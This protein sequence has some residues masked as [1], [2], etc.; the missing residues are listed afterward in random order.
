MYIRDALQNSPAKTG[1]L[2]VR[3]L[4]RDESP[5]CSQFLL[6]SA[7]KTKIRRPP[8]CAAARR[9][10]APAPT[11]DLIQLFDLIIRL[12]E[13]LLGQEIGSRVHLLGK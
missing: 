9:R 3:I 10:R 13:D 1:T 12:Q 5:L 11:E 7:A 2:R 4:M 8:G 6:V